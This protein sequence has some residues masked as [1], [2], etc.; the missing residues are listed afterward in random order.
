[1]ESLQLMTGEY[2]VPHSY[3]VFTYYQNVTARVP[4]L[5]EIGKTL[6]LAEFYVVVAKRTCVSASVTGTLTEIG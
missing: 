6:I 1:M 2:N 4:L 3:S 5:P